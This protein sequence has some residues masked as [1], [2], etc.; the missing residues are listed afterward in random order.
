VSLLS[1]LSAAP[2]GDE[3]AGAVLTMLSTMDS[4]A[5]GELAPTVPRPPGT[6]G[7]PVRPRPAGEPPPAARTVASL[8][9]YGPSGLGTAGLRIG[10]ARP[11]APSGDGTAVPELYCPPALRD[12]PALGEAVN[13]RL[14]A[15]AGEV[16]VYQGRLDQL[17]AANFGR[18]VMLAH[19]DT[20][21]A[22]RL[23][24]AAKCAVA[25][26]A[27]DDYYCDDESAG[28]TP[29]LVG[30][31]LA[32]ATAAIDPVPLPDRYAP[33]LA[34]A[35]R[36]DPVLAALRSAHDHAARYAVP[37]QL[38]R[39][40]HEIVNLFTGFNAEAGWRTVRQTPH[41]WEYLVNRQLNSFLPCMAL[42][43]VVGGYVLPTDAY[44]E[45]R[46]RRAIMHAA[47]ASTLVNDLY[48]M[49]REDDGSGYNLPTLI[50]AEDGCTLREAVRRSVAIH[51]EL[52]HDFESEA[53]VLYLS[54]PPPLQRFLAGVWAWLGGNREWHR[55]TDRYK[56]PAS[57][58]SLAQ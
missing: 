31:R 53:A 41:V 42:I 54:G 32:M 47:L 25:E 18:L 2:S 43:D 37:S 44:A 16:G 10:P 14:V 9:P 36:T 17:R 11:D 48:S 26:W 12:D 34:E 46:A 3:L 28:A 50:A 8:A 40:R 13:E 15:W 24:A 30:P 7:L 20:E 21:D 4:R 52:V 29:E 55:S 33:Q 49:A 23:L 58:G 56:N 45:P 27:A 19:P 5:P 39:L 6:G 35:A 22:D 51:D 38:A 1:R 57:T